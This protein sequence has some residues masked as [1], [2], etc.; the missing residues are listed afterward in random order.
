[1]KGTSLTVLSAPKRLLILAITVI[2]ARI[3]KNLTLALYKS[4]FE[5]KTYTSVDI[6]GHIDKGEIAT[7][8]NVTI[9]IETFY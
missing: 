4:N 3:F 9:A 6:Q 2:A 1:M 5:E 8:L 7:D